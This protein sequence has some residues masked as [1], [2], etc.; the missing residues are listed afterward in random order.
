M[1]RANI[2]A[3]VNDLR[4]LYSTPFGSKRM[5]RFILNRDQVADLLRVEV[6]HDKTINLLS[7][8]VLNDA[9][10]VLVQS[11]RSLYSVV[12]ARKATRWRKVPRAVLKDI[13]GPV[14]N[15]PDHVNGEEESE[16]GEE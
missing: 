11:G 1:A 3:A 8:A 2:D 9:G 4:D 6:A 5:G 12:A 13:I 16:D 15:G 10:L 14:D 7:K